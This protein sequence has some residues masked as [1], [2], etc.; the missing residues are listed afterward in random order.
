[1]TKENLKSLTVEKLNAMNE[2]DLRWTSHEILTRLTSEEV[3]QLPL[4]VRSKLNIGLKKTTSIWG[5]KSTWIALILS[6]LVGTLVKA[7]LS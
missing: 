6:S 5:D 3:R 4:E 2:E 1:M 7:M